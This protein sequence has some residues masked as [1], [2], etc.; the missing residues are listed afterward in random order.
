MA[1]L[2]LMSRYDFAQNP[3]HLKTIVIINSALKARKVPNHLVT[4][5]SK[6]IQDTQ[7][8]TNVN[9]YPE[10]LNLIALETTS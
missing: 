7:Q 4:A 9:S 2:S 8:A 6:E 5:T 3:R 10:E 1:K